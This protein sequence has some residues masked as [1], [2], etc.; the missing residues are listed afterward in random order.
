MYVPL[1][2]GAKSIDSVSVKHDDSDTFSLHSGSIGLSSARI[3]LGDA[4]NASFV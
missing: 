4:L 1:F 3:K 2:R